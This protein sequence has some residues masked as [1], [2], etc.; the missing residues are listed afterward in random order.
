MS[1]VLVLGSRGSE[2]ARAQTRLAEAAL[3]RILPELSI[4]LKIIT[5]SGDEGVGRGQPLDSRAGRKGLF[6]AEIERALA[7]GTIDVAVHSAKDLPSEM[8]ELLEISAVL[9]RA[10][11][12]DLLVTR[13][14][15]GLMDLAP[16]EV[17]ATGSVRRTRQLR[18]LRPDLATVDLRGNVPTRLRKLSENSWAGIILAAAGIERLGLQFESGRIRSNAAEFFVAKLEREHFVPA[19]GQGIVVLQT[20]AGDTRAGEMVREID[21]R[22]THYC[23]TAEREFLRLL[24]GDCAT[25]VGVFANLEGTTMTVRAQYF[26]EGRRDPRIGA[27]SGSS[28]SPNELA[29]ALWEKINE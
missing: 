1:G 8:D 10:D 25:P 29:R 23:L 26:E 4:A 2:L 18:W 16:G 13:L 14:P 17:I 27:V 6:T 3:R 5:T 7:A 20:R 12:H 28:T 21:H 19:G 24:K 11:V 15:G 22:P 9:P